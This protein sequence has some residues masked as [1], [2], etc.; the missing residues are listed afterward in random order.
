VADTQ[1]ID[2]AVPRVRAALRLL[3]YTI[4]YAVGPERTRAIDEMSVRSIRSVLAEL[5]AA[6]DELE[7]RVKAARGSAP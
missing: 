7:A 4:E 3:A 6:L 1:R 5:V 2:K